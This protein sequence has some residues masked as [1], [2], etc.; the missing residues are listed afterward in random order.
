MCNVH[1][2]KT[3]ILFFDKERTVGNLFQVQLVLMYGNL[4]ITKH[5]QEVEFLQFYNPKES[6]SIYKFLQ[7]R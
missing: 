3:E 5:Q 1:E 2:K 6:I 4:Y 7:T